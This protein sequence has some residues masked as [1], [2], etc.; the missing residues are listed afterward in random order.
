MCVL[1]PVRWGLLWVCWSAA[2]N[3]PCT[4]S[5]AQ[6]LQGLIPTCSCASSLAG[7]LTLSCSHVSAAQQMLWAWWA[8]P[9]HKMGILQWACDFKTHQWS[10][11]LAPCCMCNVPLS[12]LLRGWQRKGE[13]WHSKSMEFQLFVPTEIWSRTSQNCS[14]Q[15]QR[16]QLPWNRLFCLKYSPVPASTQEYRG[17]LLLQGMHCSHSD[18]TAALIPI[19]AVAG[20]ESISICSSLLLFL[21]ATLFPSTSSYLSSLLWNFCPVQ[22]SCSPFQFSPVQLQHRLCDHS[23]TNSNAEFCQ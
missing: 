20:T 5:E 3:E 19:P 4:N 13:R 22:T 12:L 14:R 21:S 10:F 8:R 7:L 2:E 6:C 11:P 18:K 16:R 15:S 9:L 23:A 1:V 17:W